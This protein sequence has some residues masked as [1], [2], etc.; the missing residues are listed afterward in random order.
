MSK[1][2]T[3]RLHAGRRVAVVTPV[4]DDWRCFQ[5]LVAAIDALAHRIG[6]VSVFAVDDGSAEPVDPDEL[7]PVSRHLEQV[8]VIHLACNLGHQRAIAV[9][10]AQVAA[11]GGFDMVIVA[12]S[13]GEDQPEEFLSLIAQH[14]RQPGAVIVA[15][16]HKRSEGYVFRRCYSTYKGL[17]RLLTGKVIDF[18][19]FCLIPAGQLDRLLHMAELWN[20]LAATIVRSRV[21][22]VKVPTVR[23][24]RY[25]G[26]S[27][28]NLVSL[29]THGLSAISV[30]SDFLFV[31]LLLFCGIAAVG[32]GALGAAALVIRM[33]TDLAVPGWA[34]TV[35][36][37]AAVIL[38]QAITLLGVATF[39]M[40]S[41]RSSAPVVPA[42]QALHYVRKT[43][44]I[45]TP[46]QTAPLPI[47][48]RN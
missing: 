16:R 14:D 35:T 8:A 21:A 7:V 41:N 42:R 43:V 32:A 18:G 15:Q 48:A 29:V 28:M 20:H 1:S 13:D 9:G 22:I 4:L 19:N 12:D 39:M 24:V 10:L 44:V 3:H 6:R 45:E 17:F 38:F 31:R 26:R 36:G 11:Q 47:A 30:F 2:E 25:A 40:L 33:S 46:C 5:S 37:I 23:G 27:R 34:T